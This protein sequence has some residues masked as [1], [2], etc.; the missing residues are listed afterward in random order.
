M[1]GFLHDSYTQD[2][3]FLLDYFKN[4][5]AGRALAIGANQGTNNP[6][7]ELI[8]RGWKAVCCE[9]DPFAVGLLIE[10]LKEYQANVTIVNSAITPTTGQLTPF[11]LS[12]GRSAMS[13]LRADWLA[14]QDAIPNDEKQQQQI[15]THPV[16]FQDL[17]NYV[18]TDFDLVVIAVEGI[19]AELIKSIDWTQLSKCQLVCVEDPGDSPYKL[20]LAGFELYHRT[21]MN[22][23]YKKTEK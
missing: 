5:P 7:Y 9:P 11:Y 23:Y 2:N 16:S 10:L 15:L 14:T 19:D 17:L 12:I 1:H 13:S 21:V 20:G 6:T 22:Y 8:K 3:D 18:G 4:L